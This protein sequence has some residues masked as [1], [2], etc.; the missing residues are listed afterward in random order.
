MGEHTT[1]DDEPSYLQGQGIGS[2]LIPRNLKMTSVETHKLDQT[3][4]EKINRYNQQ[5]L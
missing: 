2:D 4:Q 5:K 1:V 3:I